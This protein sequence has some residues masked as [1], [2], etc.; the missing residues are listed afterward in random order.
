METL[1]MTERKQSTP[2]REP[3]PP[4]PP[5]GDVSLD[6]RPVDMGGKRRISKEEWLAFTEQVRAA[7][8]LE[9]VVGQDATLQGRGDELVC[10]SPLRSD[11]GTPSFSVNG[12]KQL[13]IDR[14][15]CKGGDVFAYVMQKNGVNFAEAVRMLAERA[16]TPTPKGSARTPEEQHLAEERL[17]VEQILTDAAS[18]YHEALDDERRGFLRA[19]YGFSDRTI[20][21]EKLGYDPSGTHLWHALKAKGYSDEHIFQTGLFIEGAPTLGSTYFHHRLT[22]PYWRRNRAVYFCARAMKDTPKI[23]VR[24]KDGQIAKNADGVERF[25]D[26]SK[27]LKLT[28]RPDDPEPSDDL[29]KL[30]VRSSISATISNEWFAGE[31]VC[32]RPCDVLVIAEG[33]PD[34]LSM[35]QLGYAVISPITTTFRK[36]DQP[37]LLRLCKRAKKVVLIPDQERSGAGMVGGIDTA[38]VLAEAGIDARIAILPHEA[39]KNTAEAKLAAWVSE[40]AAAGRLITEVER[41]ASKLGDWK[42]DANEFVRDHPGGDDLRAVIG[43]ALPFVEYMVGQIPI[44]TVGRDLDARL[45]P[46]LEL[47]AEE[48]VALERERLLG[49]I[50]ARFKIRKPVLD[51]MFAEIGGKGAQE[52]DD[53]TKG[54]LLVE[55]M[56]SI[57]FV[58]ATNSR[59]FAVFGPEAIPADSPKFR[60]RVAH[61]FQQKSGG[62]LVSDTAITTALLPILGGD[63]PHGVIPIRYAH[64]EDGAILVDLGDPSRRVVRI[65]ASTCEV[66]DKSP[67]AF[68]RPDGLRP[69][70]VPVFPTNDAASKVVFD[71]TQKFLGVTLAQLATVFIWM[72]GAMRPM[73]PPSCADGEEEDDLIEYVVLKIVGG[74]GSGKSGL[75]KYVRAAVDPRRPDLVAL[76]RDL[77]DISIAAEN[78][79]VLG[80]DNISWIDRDHS[81]GL[82]RVSTGDGTEIRALYTPRDQT[83]FRGS[84]PVVVTSVTEVITETDLLSRCL[85]LWLPVR[86]TRKTKQVLRAEFRM[87]HPKLFGALCHS[88]SRVLRDLDKTVVPDTVRMQDA[89]QWALAGAS[90]AGI[91]PV[92]ILAA[93][94]KSVADADATVGEEPLVLALCAVIPVGTSWE[95][96]TTD[97]LGVLT[98]EAE[99][100]VPETGKAT[101]RLP[102][103]WPTKAR[104]L[105]SA[106]RRLEPTLKRL[107]FA[108]R[109]PAGS[110]GGEDGKQR[111]LHIERAP[112][113]GGAAKPSDGMAVEE[114]GAA[115]EP[116]GDRRKPSS[117]VSEPNSPGSDDPTVPTVA[118]ATPTLREEETTSVPPSPPHSPLS[119]SFEVQ[120]RESIVGIDEP[121]EVAENTA[122][123][124][125]RSAPS[126]VGTV[127]GRSSEPEPPPSSIQA[128]PAPHSPAARTLRARVTSA[129]VY[130]WPPSRDSDWPPADPGP[131]PLVVALQTEDGGTAY[132]VAY[133]SP[134]WP[135]RI[136]EPLGSFGWQGERA[137]DGTPILHQLDL[138]VTIEP[139]FQLGFGT[140]PTV[141]AVS[142]VQQDVALDAA[143]S[144]PINVESATADA[145]VLDP[146]LL[147]GSYHAHVSRGWTDTGR[148]EL[149]IRY[150]AEGHVAQLAHD[151]PFRGAELEPYVMSL[152]DEW[153]VTIVTFQ[154]VREEGNV[155]AKIVG[156]RRPTPQ[157]YAPASEMAS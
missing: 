98:A 142:A 125:R 67:I 42:I 116:E 14:G 112:G 43:S 143:P 32:D 145:P 49:V 60:A 83:V 111:I 147:H 127:G 101:K 65:D 77:K 99:R 113:A 44:E 16:G 68:F 85:S 92:E 121:S 23:P 19:H 124:F 95:G 74:E 70:P 157:D 25:R 12:E 38:T 120:R 52:K 140:V 33:M 56:S 36:A 137:A 82:C 45:R 114:H 62:S 129:A 72:L 81:D 151:T 110:D 4:C 7:S 50:R 109:F 46:I 39:I 61:L 58:Q 64:G 104:G 153:S 5:V 103:H 63:V 130:P 31:D 75:A 41:K 66:L 51:A 21:D 9:D 84:N 26:P 37:K 149:D 119:S 80:Y 154:Q 6:D 18:V 86:Q 53:D 117:E 55:I 13:W 1:A 146:T 141:V 139:Q 135:E 30:C 29:S 100:R 93:F 123:P 11:D 71:E 152:I 118:D 24:D 17:R 54:G 76:P 108:I 28:T 155:I 106:L 8:P 20:N 27:Y 134:I 91:A 89:A 87:L 107:D 144:V 122:D 132:Y 57:R 126:I 48:P 96:R 138:L 102:D 133:G 59:V 2:P 69:L 94:A 115:E 156:L 78:T 35:K 128:V 3:A 15:T 10:S 90:A 131:G 79:R 97:L 73:E 148:I 22:F 34:Y 40:Q 150:D 88:V 105:T 47:V 136:Y